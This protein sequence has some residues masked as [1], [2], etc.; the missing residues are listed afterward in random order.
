M[1][2]PED[3]KQR[4]QILVLIGIGVLAFIIALFQM[5]V[6]G[7]IPIMKSKKEKQE[8]IEKLDVDIGKANKEI[9]QQ[10]R[11]K[12]ENLDTL[13]KIKDLADKYVLVP[14]LGNYEIPAANYID[15]IARKLNLKI[16]SKRQQGISPETAQKFFQTFSLRISLECSYDNAVK[17]I[18]EV[19]AGNPLISV[20]NIAITGQ[21]APK[22]EQ[23]LVSFDVQW[24]VWAEQETPARIAKQL[25]DKT[26]GGSK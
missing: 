5:P 22:I 4:T 8:K 9:K 10:E 20:A 21:P 17:M 12:V 2:L 3:K 1:K 23:H 11:D 26:A 24:P 19:E 13:Q 14:E 15:A 7:I 18:K 6:I 25:S 16:D